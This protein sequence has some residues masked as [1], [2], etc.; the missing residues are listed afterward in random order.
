MKI[1]DSK[2]DK[3]WAVVLLLCIVYFGALKYSKCP[4]VD[5]PFAFVR[6]CKND[7]IDWNSFMQPIGLVILPAT[8]FSLVY[9]SLRI[10]QTGMRLLWKLCVWMARR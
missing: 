9:W 7:G 2:R 8:F 3:T 1:I 4:L 6:G 10:V 5:S